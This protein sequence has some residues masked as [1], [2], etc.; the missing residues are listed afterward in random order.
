MKLFSRAIATAVMLTASL[1]PVTSAETLAEGRI[2]TL[3]LPNTIN[4]NIG[5]INGD[6]NEDL[7][8]LY[9]GTVSIVKM[10]DQGLPIGE[11]EITTFSTDPTTIPQ[12]HDEGFIGYMGGGVYWHTKYG[13]TLEAEFRVNKAAIVDIA[14]LGEMMHGKALALRIKK[15]TGGHHIGD[16]LVTAFLDER[17]I[18]VKHMVVPETLVE[19]MEDTIPQICH[20]MNSVGDLDGD[21]IDELL[22]VRKTEKTIHPENGNYQGSQF[23]TINRATIYTFSSDGYVEDTLQF[24]AGKGLITDIE[25]Y[26]DSDTPFYMSGGIAN[27]GDLNGDGFTDI[28][29]NG[30][31]FCMDENGTFLDET[32]NLQQDLLALLPDSTFCFKSSISFKSFTAY[33]NS[34]QFLG[35]MDGD[36]YQEVSFRSNEE[37]IT[38]HR[39]IYSITPGIDK[40]IIIERSR[41]TLEK[42]S[43]P[44]LVMA[45]PEISTFLNNPA[46]DDRIIKSTSYKNSAGDVLIASDR[47]LIADPDFI[48]PPSLTD[49][50][51]MLAFMEAGLWTISGSETHSY[52]VG[53]NPGDKDLEI[54]KNGWDPVRLIA[55][56]PITQYENGSGEKVKFTD[57]NI[58]RVKVK[59]DVAFEAY[60]NNIGGNYLGNIQ[61]YFENE[62]TA[63]FE[64]NTAMDHNIT[65][66][67][68]SWI[69][70]DPIDGGVDGKQLYRFHASYEVVLPVHIVEQLNNGDNPK[71]ELRLCSKIGEKITLKQL[72]FID[73][74]GDSRRELWEYLEAFDYDTTTVLTASASW[75]K[76]TLNRFNNS[77]IDLL[78]VESTRIN[79]NGNEI[80]TYKFFE[81]KQDVSYPLYLAYM[82][83]GQL[84]Y[85]P[86]TPYPQYEELWRQC[87][88]YVGQIDQ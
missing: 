13:K 6:G 80:S 74:D 9:G 85:R 56:T 26:T 48:V 51:K 49:E 47:Y 84:A 1:S 75:D 45:K 8:C 32:Y 62:W 70:N 72:T 34:I 71:F 61:I 82:W 17:G 18:V 65:T 68:T 66:G 57:F 73:A 22:V 43:F 7:A 40:P 37:I 21:G 35:D 54:T 76:Y 15:G 44:E 86:E 41:L 30:V 11:N 58:E 53:A 3:D 81:L 5:D 2:H 16:A 33:M 50:E 27:V 77:K 24:D 36:G 25:G 59:L 29:I 38:P 12:Y 14:Y 19:Y 42:G 67:E 88:N 4:V 20:G 83:S 31:V 39:A 63:Q 60:K 10:N 69:M 46:F 78:Y 64:L 55:T 79:K 28:M 23:S 52:I 87:W